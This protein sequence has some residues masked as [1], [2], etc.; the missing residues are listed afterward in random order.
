MQFLTSIE[1]E[2]WCLRNGFS[3]SEDHKEPD[4]SLDYFRARKF[5][6]P[7]DAG[8]RIALCRMLIQSV[9]S[10]EPQ[11]LLWTTQWSIW[12]SGEHL[13]IMQSAR[14]S[15]GEDRPLIDAPGHVFHA[16]EFDSALTFFA[17][18]CL[19]LWDVSLLVAGGTTALDIS[20]DEY[21]VLFTKQPSKIDE[22]CRRFFQFELPFEELR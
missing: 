11:C 14:R 13:P 10:Q 9:W 4:L 15:Y 8:K 12:P 6:I 16:G 17:L 18:S 5:P 3:V 19:F 7:N 20:H 1:S 21:G 2:K 22:M